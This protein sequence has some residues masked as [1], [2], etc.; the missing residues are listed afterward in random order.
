MRKLQI[1][2]RLFRPFILDTEPGPYWASRC[3]VTDGALLTILN[4]RFWKV[5]LPLA[6]FLFQFILPGFLLIVLHIAFI[7]EPVIDFDDTQ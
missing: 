6:E 7:R 3:M 5:A 2:Q 4:R 1:P